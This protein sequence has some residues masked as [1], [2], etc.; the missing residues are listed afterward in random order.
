MI[1][2]LDNSYLNKLMDIHEKTIFPVWESLGR[3]HNKEKIKNFVESMFEE[4]VIYGYFRNKNILAAL[5]LNVRDDK[6]G[7]VEFILVLPEAQG[8]GVSKELMDFA[9]NYFNKKG[10]KIL[11]LD[12]VQKNERA[13]NFYKKIGYKITREFT[14]DDV[15][16]YIMEKNI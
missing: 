2:K 8:K 14:K 10:I 13:V 6:K 5:A 3:K 11:A 16:K 1:K 12:V 15:N 4:G 7:W 9:E